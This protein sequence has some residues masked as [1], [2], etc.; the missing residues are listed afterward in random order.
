MA[1]IVSRFFRSPIQ[2]LKE[3]PT[4]FKFLVVGAS[5][6]VLN[7]IVSYSLHFLIAAEL[8][9]A[10]GVELSIISNFTWNDSFTFKHVTRDMTGRNQVRLFRLLKYNTLSLA[11]AGL[12]LVVFYFLAYPLGLGH[13]V[14]YALSSFV[15][16]VAAF[17]LNYLGS[18]KWAWK[19]ELPRTSK[20]ESNSSPIND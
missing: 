15:A 17:A 13:G 18:S 8:A 2:T 19:S 3:E 6:T 5:G 11:T 7:L 20:L 12:N 4:L 1:S 10:V 14:W 16:I 9:Q